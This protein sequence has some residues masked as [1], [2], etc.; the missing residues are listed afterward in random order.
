MLFSRYP[1]PHG[2]P[3]D[4]SSPLPAPDPVI[5][6]IT[7]PHRYAYR[8]GNGVVWGPYDFEYCHGIYALSIALGNAC[9]LLELT[10]HRAVYASGHIDSVTEQ[11]VIA[12]TPSIILPPKET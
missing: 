1:E 8:M 10:T 4:D 11:K 7:P 3:P 9:D 6:D 2:F 12:S 5:T